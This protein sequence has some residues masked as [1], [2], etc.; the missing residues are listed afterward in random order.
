[1]ARSLVACFSRCSAA[2]TLASALRSCARKPASSPTGTTS[3]VAGCFAVSAL[4]RAGQLA[5]EPPHLGLEPRRLGLE[6]HRVLRAALQLGS[7]R[8][9]LLVRFVKTGLE[10]LELL[11]ELGVGDRQLVLLRG[12]RQLRR[13]GPGEE[14]TGGGKECWP[15]PPP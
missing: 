15:P 5:L 12:A 10:L 13:L 9:R 7:L 1:V 14:E 4:R 2:V 3:G 8:R 11:L 6:L